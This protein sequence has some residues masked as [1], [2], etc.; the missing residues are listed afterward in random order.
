MPVTFSLEATDY[1]RTERAVI[2]R[3]QRKSG[4]FTLGWFT[5]VFAWMFISLAI[6]SFYKLWQRDPNALEPFVYIL[7]FAVLGFLLAVLQPIAVHRTYNRYVAESNNIFSEPQHVAIEDRLLAF[8]SST[9]KSMFPPAAVI[10][11][12]EDDRNI[13]L[14][15]SANHA[16]PVPKAVVDKLGESFNPFMAGRKNEA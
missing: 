1:A 5:Q 6:F 7:L 2:N 3:L 16:V 4:R 10:D 12:S 15:L 13:Y 9:G 11:H 14:F 8:E